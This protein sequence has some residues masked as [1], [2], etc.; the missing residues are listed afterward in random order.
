MVFFGAVVFAQGPVRWLGVA[1]TVL[2]A[3]ALIA[4][5]VSSGERT[6]RP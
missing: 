3:A 6:A 1:A 2:A 5:D 4:P